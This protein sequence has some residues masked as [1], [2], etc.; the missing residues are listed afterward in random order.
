MTSQENFWIVAKE[1]FT[2]VFFYRFRDFQYGFLKIRLKLGE[3]KIINHSE[4]QKSLITL[5]CKQQSKKLSPGA[6]PLSF[7]L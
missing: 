5:D 6:S 1:N 4:S 7:L 2:E 3:K